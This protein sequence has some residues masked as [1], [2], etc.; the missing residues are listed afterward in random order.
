M[1]WNTAFSKLIDQIECTQVAWSQHSHGGILVVWQPTFQAICDCPNLFSWG[2]LDQRDMYISLFI[3]WVGLRVVH[4]G[5]L[6]LWRRLQGIAY[7]LN[8]VFLMA[9]MNKMISQ[10]NQIQSRASRIRQLFLNY[11]GM[12]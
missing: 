5:W 6:N 8:W 7:S 12:L 1:V 11:P 9:P 10:L 2:V 4:R 3:G